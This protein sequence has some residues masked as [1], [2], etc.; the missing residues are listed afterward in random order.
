MRK[1][2]FVP[3][4]F[5]VNLLLVVYVFYP[6]F[7][8][9]SDLEKQ[10]KGAKKE[11]QNKQAYF[12][13]LE[14]TSKN[15]EKHKE[16]FKKIKKGLPEKGSLPS[17]LKF[18][19]QKASQNGLILTSISRSQRGSEKTEEKKKAQPG[20]KFD[21]SLQGTY[22]SV[23]SFLNSLENSSRLTQ[24]KN[25]SIGKK[26]EAETQTLSFSISLIVFSY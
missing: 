16:V 25:F 8:S 12:S 5:L 23:K 14:E 24:V 2:I 1:S 6:T 15:L 17:L 18:F 26:E 22:S 19:Q 21:L 10:L 3:I 7:S 9:V 4:L 20:E 11:L 13:Q